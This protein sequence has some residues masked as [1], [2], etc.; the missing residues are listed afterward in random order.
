MTTTPPTP[1]ATRTIAS[2][3]VTDVICI[4]LFVAVGRRNHAEGVTVAGVAQTAWPF[5]AGLVAAW[6]VYRAWR[7]PTTISPTG[8]SIW[9][10]TI[11]AGMVLRAAIG[12]GIAISFI[13]VAT[14]VTGMLLLGWR[15]IVAGLA[16]RPG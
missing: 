12:A 2:A 16:R 11:A 6:V 13:L 7:R 5:L 4:L 9:L 15:A 8:V 14:T 3:F 1:V 10:T